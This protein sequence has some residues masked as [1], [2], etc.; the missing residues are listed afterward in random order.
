MHHA[1]DMLRA[2]TDGVVKMDQIY[3]CR[4]EVIAANQA[5]SVSVGLF[6]DWE[7][8]RDG[9]STVQLIRQHGYRPRTG[10]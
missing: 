1:A 9:V 6:R 7:R 10:R 8:V 5:G 3:P 2:L 4:G